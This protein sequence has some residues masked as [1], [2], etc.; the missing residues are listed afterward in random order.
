LLG[1]AI[2]VASE[3]G[4]GSVFHLEIMLFED[5]E[6]TLEERSIYEAP[7]E[8]T[9]TMLTVEP[10]LTEALAGIDAILI[11]K[12]LKAV[13]DADLDYLLGLIEVTAESSPLLAGTLRDLAKGF[14]YDAI[15]KLLAVGRDGHE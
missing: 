5:G 4:Q 14:Q 7:S 9:A 3:P 15:G 10:P 13:T 1:G 11:A 12:M 6:N 8:T 2:T